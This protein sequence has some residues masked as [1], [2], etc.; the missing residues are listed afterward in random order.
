MEQGSEEEK[1]KGSQSQSSGVC[2]T[3]TGSQDR[4]KRVK[5]LGVLAGVRW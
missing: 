3:V 1:R 4:S 2:E 5:E